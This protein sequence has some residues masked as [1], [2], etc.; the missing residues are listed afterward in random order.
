MNFSLSLTNI[1][2]K[3]L[4]KNRPPVKASR[5][6][7]FIPFKGYDYLTTILLVITSLVSVS[8]CI[9]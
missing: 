4:Q 1:K 6:N 2:Q 3:R 7:K 5:F 8:T 9:M